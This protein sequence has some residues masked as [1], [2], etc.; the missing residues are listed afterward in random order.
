MV[1]SIGSSF[2]NGRVNGEETL[3]VRVEINAK[4][5]VRGSSH[6]AR[7]LTSCQSG[8]LSLQHSAW[9]VAVRHLGPNVPWTAWLTKE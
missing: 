4:S 2:V 5:A 6:E 3:V 7:L 9:T 8:I 1:D